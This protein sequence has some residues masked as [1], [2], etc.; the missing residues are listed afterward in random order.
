MAQFCE[1]DEFDEF[2]EFGE[3]ELLWM[4]LSTLATSC[5]ITMDSFAEGVQIG[6]VEPYKSARLL[7]LDSIIVKAWK[8]D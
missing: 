4:C 1:F 2:D 7:K 5:W 3:F 8:I 6:N